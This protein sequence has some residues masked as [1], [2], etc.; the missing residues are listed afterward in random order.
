M[1]SSAPDLICGI[2]PKILID[3]ICVEPPST[4]CIAGPPPGYGIGVIFTLAFD[5]K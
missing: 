5:L 1:V 4:A 2:N 3:P